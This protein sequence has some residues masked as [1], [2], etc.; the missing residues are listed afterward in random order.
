M[1]NMKI[2][3]KAEIKEE[4][5]G[6]HIQESV[7][8]WWWGWDWKR[9]YKIHGGRLTKMSC[10]KTEERNDEIKEIWVSHYFWKNAKD[11]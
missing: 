9:Y 11:W 10:R 4:A 6:I 3:K 8:H 7:G 2:G 5:G 1:Q